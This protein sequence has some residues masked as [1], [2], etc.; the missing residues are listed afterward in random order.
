MSTPLEHGYEIHI[1]ILSHLYFDNL[2]IVTSR[3]ILNKTWSPLSPSYG[4]DRDLDLNEVKI[5]IP[6]FHHLRHIFYHQ[7]DHR[8]LYLG[9]GSVDDIDG[10]PE[11]STAESGE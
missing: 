10:L 2:T 11:S 1:K 4:E 9:R 5:I 7:D 8:H 6:F 3:V